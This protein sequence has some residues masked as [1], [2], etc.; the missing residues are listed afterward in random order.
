[1]SPV[2]RFF[3]VLAVTFTVSATVTFLAALAVNAISKR[4]RCCDA[5]QDLGQVG[6]NQ[7]VS[8]N[9]CAGAA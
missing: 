5:R 2:A 1:M 4:F 7:S 8:H 3:V 6:A 9:D